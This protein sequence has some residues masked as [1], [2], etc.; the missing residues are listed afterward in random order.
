MGGPRGAQNPANSTQ[1]LP[2]VSLY[3]PWRP[4][5]DFL[6]KE[7]TFTKHRYVISL[8]HILLALGAP[9]GTPLGFQSRPK[10][11][12]MPLLGRLGRNLKTIFFL[13]GPRGSFW[14]Q[15]GSI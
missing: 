9:L 2:K 14:F 6:R 8:K 12:Q 1:G 15:N 13:E 11:A 4:R 10:G 5:G 7:V 3:G